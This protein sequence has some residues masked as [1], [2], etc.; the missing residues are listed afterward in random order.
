MT[1]LNNL[2]KD[3]FLLEAS[4]ASLLTLLTLSFSARVVAKGGTTGGATGGGTT[5]DGTS[6]DG[7]SATPAPFGTTASNQMHYTAGTAMLVWI[8]IDNLDENDEREYQEG[9]KFVFGQSDECK[10]PYCSIGTCSTG[11]K[12]ENFDVNGEPFCQCASLTKCKEYQIEQ[13]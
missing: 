6:G 13:R 7:T 3:D 2:N 4:K 9:D 5:G 11:M 1:F 12:E 10:V 8:S